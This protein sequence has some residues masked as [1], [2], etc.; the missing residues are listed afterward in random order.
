[1]LLDPIFVSLFD[2]CSYNNTACL[3]ISIKLS[4]AYMDKN[5]ASMLNDSFFLNLNRFIRHS[6]IRKS[7]G[8]GSV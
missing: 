5:I 2:D 3:P 6:S 4:E 7:R 1:M 8:Q